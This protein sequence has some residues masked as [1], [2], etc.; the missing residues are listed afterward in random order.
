MSYLK[1]LSLFKILDLRKESREGS[2][3]VE[4]VVKARNHSQ[5]IRRVRKN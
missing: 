1:T 4:K 2:L 5:R 3:I